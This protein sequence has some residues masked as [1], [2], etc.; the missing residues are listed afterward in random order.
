[1][2]MDGGTATRPGADTMPVRIDQSDVRA[3]RDWGSGFFNARESRKFAP[4]A[5]DVIQIF[6]RRLEVAINVSEDKG[7]QPSSSTAQNMR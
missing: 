4:T 7:T 2:A 5:S 6:C 3:W 1:M